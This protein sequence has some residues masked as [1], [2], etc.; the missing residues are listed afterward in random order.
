[1]RAST[2]NSNRERF[3]DSL[4][5]YRVTR[6][7]AS[8]DP[9]RRTSWTVAHATPNLPW[10]LG[11][12]LQ[13]A[14]DNGGD[15]PSV[16]LSHEAWTRDFGED[17]RVLGSAIRI[18][19]RTVRVAG[20][21]AYGSWRLPGR[22]D[23]FLLESSAALSSASSAPG[24]VIGQLSALGKASMN[25]PYIAI[26]QQGGDADDPDFEGVALGEHIDGPSSIFAFSLFLALLALPAVTS[27][28]M[29]ESS[30]SSHRPSW[31]RRVQRW[32][33]LA[34]KVVLIASIAG[35][36]SLILAYW[37]VESYSQTSEFLQF[38][39]SFAL[40]LFGLRWALL[41]QRQRCPVC[42][43]RV[44]HPAQVGLASRTFLGW[45]GTEMI[46]TGGHTLLHV[47][48]LPTSWFST[49]RWL[50]LDTSWEFLFAGVGAP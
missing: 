3:F 49:Q 31:K 40:S 33:F 4:A 14:A 19:T 32:L 22:P 9:S 10:L 42:L 34:A 13:S 21:L 20:V 15:L 36:A 24:Y 26:A 47:P 45:N 50:Y 8:R 35:L 7:S 44:T 39:S 11:L 43:R 2:W 16:I 6:E 18:G 28:S 12:P 25:G 30:F 17:R 48:S 41:D 38:A 29:S 27:V 5:F 37:R 46:C 23:A 1:L